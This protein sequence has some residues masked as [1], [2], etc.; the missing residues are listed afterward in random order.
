MYVKKSLRQKKSALCVQNIF[1]K[2]LRKKKYIYIKTNAQISK[3]KKIC[4]KKG[5]K[6]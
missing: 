2:T 1:F 6:G 4:A 5:R 3:E